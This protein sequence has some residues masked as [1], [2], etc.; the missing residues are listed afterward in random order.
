MLVIWEEARQEAR[1]HRCQGRDNS[2]PAQESKNRSLCCPVTSL[3]LVR[4]IL[5]LLRIARYLISMKQREDMCWLEDLNTCFDKVDHGF[6][7][8]KLS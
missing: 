3:D 5:L 7:K 8:I 2:V 4:R 1:H 6:H